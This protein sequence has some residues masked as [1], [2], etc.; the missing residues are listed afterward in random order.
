[1]TAPKGYRY[2][3]PKG[4]RVNTPSFYRRGGGE[5]F[6]QPSFLRIHI[7]IYIRRNTFFFLL[8]SCL[9]YNLTIFLLLL[10][11]GVNIDDFSLPEFISICIIFLKISLVFLAILVDGK[12]ALK[13]GSCKKSDSIWT[14]FPDLPPSQR[15]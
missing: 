6:D 15:K 5:K 7:Y 13:F 2:L 8:I 1:M 10:N 4:T 12:G 14:P 11:L 3:N 9:E